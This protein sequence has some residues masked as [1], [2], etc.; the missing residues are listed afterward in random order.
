[1]AQ[2]KPRNIFFI[3]IITLCAIT[4]L[5]PTAIF[6]S[7]QITDLQNQINNLQAPKLVN[8][9]L[10]YSDNNQG[11]IYVKGYV[12][13]AGNV[14]ADGCYVDVHLSTDSMNLNSTYLYFGKDPSLSPIFGGH[15]VLGKTPAYVDGNISYTGSPPT[16][17][18][19]TLGWTAPWQIPVP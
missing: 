2:K 18:T 17:V 8:I 5:S 12:Y 7:L 15:Y 1:M 16:N 9:S 14:T 13:N 10:G 4:V 11:T 19:L 3:V 6:Y